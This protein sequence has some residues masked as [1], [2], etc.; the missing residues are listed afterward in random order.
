MWARGVSC[1]HA[2]GRARLP[3]SQPDTL[4]ALHSQA[5]LD[6]AKVECRNL[7]SKVESLAADAS[8]LKTALA[9]AQAAAAGSA[10][11]AASARGKCGRLHQELTKL[12]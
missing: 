7:E 5:E 3:A 10:A 8:G 2:T 11:E 6:R 9:S 1:V 12:R 4:I